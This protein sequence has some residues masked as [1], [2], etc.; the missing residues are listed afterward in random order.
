MKK[1]IQTMAWYLV[2]LIS[3]M[4]S[5]SGEEWPT[6]VGPNTRAK[7]FAGILHSVVCDTL[8]TIKRTPF[9]NHISYDIYIYITMLFLWNCDTVLLRPGVLEITFILCILNDKTIHVKKKKLDHKF[10][11]HLSHYVV[12][13]CAHNNDMKCLVRQ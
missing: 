9:L 2:S 1:V 8:N 3:C 4:G 5:G 12:L 7:L 11:L 10:C 6:R 13:F